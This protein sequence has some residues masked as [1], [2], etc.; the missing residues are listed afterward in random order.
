MKYNQPFHFCNFGYQTT[1]L[2]E[3]K[4]PV[5]YLEALL[6]STLRF[7]NLKF[8]LLWPQKRLLFSLLFSYQLLFE[9]YKFTKVLFI[10]LFFFCPWNKKFKQ[11]AAPTLANAWWSIALLGIWNNTLIKALTDQTVPNAKSQKSVAGLC[12]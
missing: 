3:S 2:T 6:Y 5:L 9:C 1:F 7:E 4:Y 10:F 8:S 11:S 12:I